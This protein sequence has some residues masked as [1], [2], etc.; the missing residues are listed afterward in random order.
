MKNWFDPQTG[1]LLFDELL[2]ERET[3]RKIMEDDIVSPKEVLDQ[4]KLVIEKLH[5]LEAKL[6]DEQ[7]ESAADAIAE[8]AVLFAVSN[9]N[10]LKELKIN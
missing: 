8:L 6:S 5:V 3:F 1:I 9:Y 7:K 4:S 2:Q 10:Q